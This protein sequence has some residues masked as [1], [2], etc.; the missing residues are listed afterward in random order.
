MKAVL[1]QGVAFMV[2]FSC[3]VGEPGTLLSVDGKT[4]SQSYPTDYQMRELTDELGRSL[5]LA[6]KCYSDQGQRRD[7]PEGV[8][9]GAALRPVAGYAQP[10]RSC[11]IGSM[12]APA[13]CSDNLAKLG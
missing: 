7:V 6:A 13:S 12:R 5:Q 10:C 11:F 2:M 9:D 3:S 4:S 8:H 1:T